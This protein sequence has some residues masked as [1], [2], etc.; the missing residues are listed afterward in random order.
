MNEKKLSQPNLPDN[1]M[2]Q[3]FGE[4]TIGDYLKQQNNDWQEEIIKSGEIFNIDIYDLTRLMNVTAQRGLFEKIEEL[5][6]VELVIDHKLD[7]E[8]V[9][10]WFERYRYFHLILHSKNTQM[11]SFSSTKEQ[12]VL[13]YYLQKLNVINLDIVID[14]QNKARVI[15][16]LCN[17]E[18][19]NIRKAIREVNIKDLQEKY[20]LKPVLRNILKLATE[21]GYKELKIEVEADLA[22]LYKNL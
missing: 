10:K 22:R 9:I 16:F 15:S 5:S 12:I 6:V 3:K 11:T 14:Q 4:G 19:E 17:R 21:I 1:E 18:Y 8:V 20:M 13:Y 2:L 7:F